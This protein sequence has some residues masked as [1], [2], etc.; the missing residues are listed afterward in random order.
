MINLSNQVY[1]KLDFN[2]YQAPIKMYIGPGNNSNLI[3]SLMKKRFWF[4]EVTQAKDANFVWTQIK[5]DNMFS[6]QPMS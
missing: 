2:S 6:N 5:I 1:R 4:V 3:R